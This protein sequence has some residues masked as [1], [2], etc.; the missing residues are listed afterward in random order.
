MGHLGSSFLLSVSSNIDNF[1]LGI[2]SGAKNLKIGR[3]SNLTIAIFSAIGAFI[4]MSLGEKLGRFLSAD[5]ANLLGFIALLSVGFWGLWD[6]FRLHKKETLNQKTPSV[7]QLDYTIFIEK[8]ETADLD[9]SHFIDV[10]E[11]L[12]LALALTI[13]NVA[14]GFGA[15]LSGLNIPVTTFLT[16]FFSLL[17]IEFGYFMGKK[18]TSRISAKWSGII[19]ASLIICLAVYEYFI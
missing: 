1:A 2:A 19:S 3:L 4:S 18:F 8:P 16:F 10:R 6:T 5:L 17:A 11:S 13:N 12:T 7:N 9:N 14:G 15:G